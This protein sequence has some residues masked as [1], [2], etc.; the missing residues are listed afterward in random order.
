MSDGRAL[1]ELFRARNRADY[2]FF[3]EFDENTVD[4]LIDSARHLVE[5]AR[6]LLPSLL[7]GE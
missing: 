5:V 4:A 2:A 3:V 7:E 1:H 6:E